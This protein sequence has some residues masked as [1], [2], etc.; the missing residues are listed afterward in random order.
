VRQ[1]NEILTRHDRHA[2]RIYGLALL[3]GEALSNA[4]T[5]RGP[6]IPAHVEQVAGDCPAIGGDEE[7][8]DDCRTWATCYH[9]G[10]P[11][12]CVAIVC[13]SSASRAHRVPEIAESTR[14]IAVRRCN[15]PWK[16]RF[17]DPE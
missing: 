5:K 3:F 14:T 12:I 9:K 16:L 17:F 11:S 10:A 15:L 4:L 2:I 6:P 7:A 13:R 1:A 8:M